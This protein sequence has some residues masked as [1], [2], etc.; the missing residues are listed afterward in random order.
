M[1]DAISLVLFNPVKFF[2]KFFEDDNKYA[3]WSLFI[4]IAVAILSAISAFLTVAPMA[5][6]M[7]KNPPMGLITT[8]VTVVSSLVM[9][10][11]SWLVRGLIIS[12]AASKGIKP[13]AIAAYS[14]TPQVLL[15]TAIIVIAALFPIE[16]PNLNLNV[17]DPAAMQAATQRITELMQTSVYAQASKYLT[18]L[19]IAWSLL[20]SYLGIREGAGNSKAI[21]AT[22]ILAALSALF[23][24]IPILLKPVGG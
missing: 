12:M 11:V 14:F 22:L 4:V 24:L 15:A 16:L 7:P 2:K 9:I 3:S 23:I 6:L 19:G 5:A 10:F 1:L 21:T 18:Y 20:L 8:L 13:W 17:Q